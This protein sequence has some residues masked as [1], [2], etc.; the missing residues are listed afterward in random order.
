[1]IDQ[2]AGGKERERLEAALVAI[3]GRTGAACASPLLPLVQSQKSEVRVIGLHAL[4][5][6]GGPRALAATVAALED[7]DQAVQDEAARSLSTWPNNWPD[8]KNAA[9]PL[10]ALAKSGKRPLHKTLGL[11]GYLQ[12][13]QG[14]KQLRG[15]AKVAKVAEVLPLLTGPEDKRMAITAL[16]G[17]TTAKALDLLAGFAAEKGVTEE[18]CAAILEAAARGRGGVSAE[19]KQKALQV[20]LEQSNKDSTKKKAKE[21]L[22]EKP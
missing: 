17:V 6:A 2:Q 15:D 4:A 10:L 9:E 19:Q 20:V 1:L 22:G 3:A 16:H 13:V 14:D 12:C 21:L 5:A 11:R 8:D 18:A 7:S